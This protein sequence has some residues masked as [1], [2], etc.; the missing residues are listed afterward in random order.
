MVLGEDHK[1]K[2]MAKKETTPAEAGNKRDVDNR[3]PLGKVNYILMAVCLALIVLGFFLM[4]GSPNEG[5]TFNE[6]VFETRR[7]VVGPLVSLAGF[8]LMAFAIIF[9]R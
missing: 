6:A 2:D 8:V 9:K 7:V 4:A 1:T 3:L 5:T